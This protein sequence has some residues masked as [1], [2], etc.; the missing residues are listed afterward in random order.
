MSEI[1]TAY[2]YI[3]GEIGDFYPYISYKNEVLTT[4]SGG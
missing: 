4:I 2:R 1:T 3:R